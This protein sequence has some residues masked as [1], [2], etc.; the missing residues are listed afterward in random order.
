MPHP[1]LCYGVLRLQA[2]GRPPGFREAP[3]ERVP[4]CNLH[5]N[6]GDQEGAGTR[7]IPRMNFQASIA[8][9]Y[10]YL[11][12]QIDSTHRLRPRGIPIYQ[13]PPEAAAELEY[14]KDGF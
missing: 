7:R 4:R 9:L 13:K 2:K 12:P 14:S 6:L 1:G 8:I 5:R 3:A 11:K 10:Y